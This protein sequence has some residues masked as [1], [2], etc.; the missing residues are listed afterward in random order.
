MLGVSVG[1][2]KTMTMKMKTVTLFGKV[3]EINSKIFF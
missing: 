1:E 3:Y 2:M